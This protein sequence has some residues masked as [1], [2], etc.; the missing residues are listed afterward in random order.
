MGLELF[1]RGAWR[2]NGLIHSQRIRASRQV[3]HRVAV[4][5]EFPG[6]GHLCFFLL[7]G[8]GRI[9]RLHLRDPLHMAPSV[10]CHAK[11]RKSL[12]NIPASQRL[13]QEVGPKAGSDH[14]PEVE[15]LAAGYG[16]GVAS[17]D[18]NAYD[19]LAHWRARV[20]QAGL[21]PTAERR[22]A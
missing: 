21:L 5:G 7:S 1:R 22:V 9:A 19:R 10:R 17:V 18:P 2:G 8:H 4:K 20:E 11:I 13:G 3:W 6:C 14:A 12:A 16:L 15:V